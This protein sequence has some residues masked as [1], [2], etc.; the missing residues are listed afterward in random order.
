MPVSSGIRLSTTNKSN[1][2][3][4]EQTLRFARARGGDDLMPIFA[5]SLGEGIEDLRLIIDQKN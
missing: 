2:P 1:M 5:Q 4:R 3:L